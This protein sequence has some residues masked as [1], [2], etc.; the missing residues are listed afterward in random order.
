M[1]LDRINIDCF[2][3]LRRSRES[4]SR[5]FPDL[6]K[7]IKAQ[8]LTADH[9]RKATKSSA[10]FLLSLQ[11]TNGCHDVDGRRQCEEAVSYF[12]ENPAETA[13]D[14]LQP[15]RV[16]ATLVYSDFFEPSIVLDYGANKVL[17]AI[18]SWGSDSPPTRDQSS[19]PPWAMLR[20]GLWVNYFC[21]D[22]GS[23]QPRSYTLP[24]PGAVDP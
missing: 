10:S 24:D 11:G 19:Q 17:A 23:G 3:P 5:G 4:L 21:R 14:V 22:R 9:L 6:S 13:F 16:C 12:I 1:L 18:T 7:N 8:S 2:S 15:R 20:A